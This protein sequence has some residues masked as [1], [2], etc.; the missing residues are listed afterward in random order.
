MADVRVTVACYDEDDNY[1]G[2]TSEYFDYIPAKTDCKLELY[3]HEETDSV[4]IVDVVAY[5]YDE[6]Y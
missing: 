2:T 5:Y 1:L 4:E 6:A 3:L